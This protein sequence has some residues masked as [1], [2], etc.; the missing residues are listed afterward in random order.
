MASREATPSLE[1][2]DPTILEE[3]NTATERTFEESPTAD[4][5]EAHEG[6]GSTEQPKRLRQIRGRHRAAL[7]RLYRRAETLMSEGATRAPLQNVLEDMDSALEALMDINTMLE[8][9]LQREDEQAD[10]AHYVADVCAEKQRITDRIESYL[11]RISEQPPTGSTVCTN[12]DRAQE[13]RPE[14]DLDRSMPRVTRS[15]ARRPMS[16]ASSVASRASAEAQISARLKE[17]RVRQLEQERAM[18]KKEAE[19]QLQIRQKE[20]ELRQQ[21]EEL[22]Y[23]RDLKKAQDEAEEARLEAQLRMEMEDQLNAD[24]RDDFLHE[25]LIELDKDK[26]IPRPRDTT[27]NL[28]PTEPVSVEPNTNEPPQIADDPKTPQKDSPRQSTGQASWIDQ[29]QPTPM[30]YQA[31]MVPAFTKSIPR[32]GLHTFS[33]EP[34]EWPGWIGLFRALVH[35]QPTLSD[36]ERMAHLQAAVTGPAKQAISGMLYDGDLYTH[37]LKTLQDRFG[38]SRDIV[39]VHLDGMFSAQPP[40]ENDAASL[41]AFQSTLHCAVTFLK[42]QGYEGDIVSTENLRRTVA[43]LPQYLRRKWADFELEQKPRELSLMDMDA[44]LLKQAQAARL[45]Q[46]TETQTSSV[47]DD[48]RKR[49][50]N[51]PATRATLATATSPPDV[52]SSPQGPGTRTVCPKCGGEHRLYRCREFKELDVE[53]RVDL[54]FA[55]GLCLWCLQKGHIAK[56]C[57]NTKLCGIDGCQRRHN[58][59]IHGGGM[60]NAPSSARS[61]EAGSHAAEGEEVQVVT[62]STR[63]GKTTGTLLQIVP[64]RIHGKHDDF[65]DTYALLDP[66]S[67]S[68]FCN[69]SVLNRLKLKGEKSQLSLQTVEGKGRPQI[70]TKVRLELSSLASDEPQRITVPE[71]WTVPSLN[72]NMPNISQKQRGKWRHIQDLD[73]PQCSEGQVELLL[74]ANV[75]EA[76]IQREIRIGQPGQPI[77]V[78]TAFGW[79]LTGNVSNLRSEN[80]RRVMF[81]QKG[82]SHDTELDSMLKDWWTTE[83]FGTKYEKT[84]SQSKEDRRAQDIL[85]STTTKIEDNRYETGLLWKTDNVSL[86][87]SKTMATRRLHG[88][89]KRLK[90]SPEK[91]AAYQ[92]TIDSYLE[93]GHAK[94][95]T[96]DEI[97]DTRHRRWFLPH[98]AVTNPNKPG[99]FR[100]V[101]DAAAK[102]CG[103]SLNDKLLTG[104]DLLRNLTGVLLRFR[105]EPVGIVADIQEMYHQV[106]VIEQDRPALSFL[107]RDL[108]ESKD[109][110]IYEMQVTIFGA[111]SSPASA[112]FVLQK[113]VMDH[114]EM[115]GL[116]E[117][118]A[119]SVK[120]SF[121]MDD[122]L[123]SEK[124]DVQAKK[125]QKDVTEMLS[126]GGFRLTKWVSNS[127][128]VMKNVSQ[129]ERA[130]PELDLSETELPIEGALGV[131]WNPEEDSLSFRLRDANVPVTKR[132][133]L[134]RTASIFDPLGI[135]APFVIRAKMLI[136]RLWTMQLDWDDELDAEEQEQWEDWLKELPEL[137]NISIPRCMRPTSDEALTREL[138]VFCDASEGAFGAVA[139]LRVTLPDKTHHCS[140]VMSKTRV[141]PLKRLSIVRLELQAAVL[142]VRL[143]D[144]L[145]KEIPSQVQQVTYWSDSKVVLQYISNE[146]RRFHTFVSNRV[147]EIHDL[148]DKK[149]WRHCP[150][151]WNPADM[152]SRGAEVSELANSIW[153]SGPDFLREDEE[154]WPDPIPVQDLTQEDAEVKVQSF[155][156]AAVT[157]SGTALPDPKK[158]TSWTKYKR[159]VAWLFRFIHNVKLD[160]E[161]KRQR[162]TGPLT[163]QEIE[164]AEMIIIKRVQTESYHEELK[165]LQAGRHV[166]KKQSNISDLSPVLDEDG[167]LRVGGR[168]SNAPLNNDA[169]HPILLPA[170]S[171]EARMIIYEKHRKLMHAGI[172]HTLN[173]VRQRFWIP[174]GRAQVKRVLLDCAMCRNRR[175]K[176]QAPRMADLPADRYD[177]SHPFSTVGI[178]YFGPLTVK[179]FRKT[180]KRYGLLVTCLATRAIHLEVSNS[181]DTD[182]FLMAFRRF[183]AR[184][185]QPKKVFS[186]N[187][188]NLKGG[189]RELREALTQWNQQKIS[190]EL[191]Q[192]HIEW[193]FNPPAASHMGGIWERLVGSVKRA[194][195][196]VLGNEVTTDEVLTTIFCE[197]ENMINSRPLTHVTDDARDLTALTPN[198]FLLGRGGRCL[199]PGAFSE[200][201][202]HTRKRWRYT[203]ALT[204]HLW[205]RWRKE[206]LH[207]LIHR[208]RW[209][210]DGRNLAVGDL[211]LLADPNTPRGHWPLAR[212]SQVFPGPDNRIRTVQIKTAAGGTYARPATKVALLEAAETP[213]NPDN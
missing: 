159:S 14:T 44:W 33:G 208:R 72:I 154:H 157:D 162:H 181:L 210:T 134:Q 15:M 36:A 103:T 43:K 198:H 84:V 6:Q 107:W 38:Q 129:E 155:V 153:L 140:F 8:S 137:K 27:F 90:G 94:K 66:G 76:V 131:V 71:A 39:R 150:S 70:S 96:K 151:K 93:K 26:T 112:N 24:R 110:D 179:R 80:S 148:S 119:N 29:L 1:Q 12:L 189:E 206:Y 106:R 9:S 203:Q 192:Q 149:Q 62:A 68:S 52:T 187:G 74:G 188:T 185:G 19:M 199:P 196:V 69:E 121:Y 161:E 45:F 3:E 88:T 98:H 4:H 174:R 108:D 87:D 144:A 113:T 171:E 42:T 53:K 211:V 169:R 86:P 79:T 58:Q 175:A 182:S 194:L 213:P 127:R 111:K 191:S 64:V 30:P 126:K 143:V 34:S 212:V 152:C 56:D 73:I 201:D 41:E 85:E 5:D 202:L 47:Q 178:D 59:L 166:L 184:R 32:L 138:H 117:E 97:N 63:I 195:A 183:V 180:E 50:K 77:A 130:H 81:V 7:T 78:R 22:Q 92:A 128:E 122:F 2:P 60:R 190:D 102:S 136:Q 65:L 10:A 145:R 13:G 51:P 168:L 158:F 146:S 163:A 21:E 99:K 115:C 11:T 135:A 57:H 16:Q 35:N 209:K 176:P 28:R 173:E 95:L 18:R 193:R 186:D 89:E 200:H 207:T 20:E 83:A 133:I 67:E 55:R 54:I 177:D 124:D 114:R 48:K 147:A 49:V 170:K 160:K 91:A 120:N 164:D 104:P 25:D 142:A 167:V 139:Y 105:E 141:A 132:G 156:T 204:D 61:R 100:V 31:N 40:Q 37:A 172:D 23:Q 75:S 118:T 17:L 116:E 109:P 82:S 101:F 197:V 125:M 46:A 165:I 205:R 123:R